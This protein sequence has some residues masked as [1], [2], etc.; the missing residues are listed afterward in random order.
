M[1]GKVNGN[2]GFAQTQLGS[3]EGSDRYVRGLL[4][5]ARNRVKEIVESI[6]MAPFLQAGEVISV[7]A[8][9]NSKSQGVIFYKCK[10]L[11]VEAT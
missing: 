5:L 10:L 2:S 11:Q 3:W 1:G 9:E 8:T 6:K 4:W 7:F